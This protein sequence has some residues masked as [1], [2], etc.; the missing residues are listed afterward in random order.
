MS[1]ANAPENDGPNYDNPERAQRLREELVRREK[2]EQEQQAE[3]LSIKQRLQKKRDEKTIEQDFMGET[4]EFRPA[5]AARQKRGI[6]LSQRFG[7]TDED[8][9][10]A[11]VTA[12][13]VDYMVGTL[14]ELSVNE[15]LDE[16]FWGTYG[17]EDLE[18]VFENVIAA[19]AA[20]EVT[21]EEIDEF[22]GE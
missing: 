20:E 3:A 9:L 2:T 8:E 18:G 12:D 17:F 22:R 4:L 1:A 14:A 7:G 11:E 13:L 16:E 19:G 15:E 10:D 6:V 21:D 5:G